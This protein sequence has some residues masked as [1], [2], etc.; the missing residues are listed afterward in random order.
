MLGFVVVLPIILLQEQKSIAWVY[1]LALI[2]NQL[3]FMFTCG[4]MIYAVIR[5]TQEIKAVQ[6]LIPKTAL[7]VAHIVLLTLDTVLQ[8]LYYIW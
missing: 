3:Q 8:F 6:S 2:P 1:F 7:V 5:L 4:S